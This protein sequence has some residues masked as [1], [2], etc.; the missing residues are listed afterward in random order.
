[1]PLTISLTICRYRLEQFM[2][3]DLSK[4]DMSIVFAHLRV[5]I[6]CLDK[7]RSNN[8]DRQIDE[9]FYILLYTRSIG[10]SASLIVDTNYL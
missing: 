2:E 9:N 10:H 8:N 3:D 7:R 5:M 4:E 6:E 1:M